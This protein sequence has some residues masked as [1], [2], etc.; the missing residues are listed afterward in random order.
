[1]HEF[2]AL[3]NILQSNEMKAEFVLRRGNTIVWY[4]CGRIVC[5]VLCGVCR[6]YPLHDFISTNV[7]T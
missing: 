6:V 1:M 3:V 2:L 7:S 4:V 5:N